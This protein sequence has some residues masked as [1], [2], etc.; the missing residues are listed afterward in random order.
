MQYFSI[1]SCIHDSLLA[2]HILG[3]D[4]NLIASNNAVLIFVH[5]RIPRHL[6]ST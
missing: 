2:Y 6:N 4:M 5:R 3:L 1:E